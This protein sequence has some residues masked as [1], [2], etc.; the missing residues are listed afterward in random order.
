M[1][2]LQQ[3]GERL[4]IAYCDLAGAPLLLYGEPCRSTTLKV[5]SQKSSRR[6][7]P[8]LGIAVS[9]AGATGKA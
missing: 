2:E 3:N 6:L 9:G 1:G 7:N 4:N 8:K 5:S